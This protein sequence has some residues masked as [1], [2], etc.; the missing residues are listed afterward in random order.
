MP[1]LADQIAT[2]L[3]RA[4][5]KV[6]D[7]NPKAD[8]ICTS[9]QTLGARA[10]HQGRK[11]ASAKSD[12]NGIDGL[13]ETIKSIARS[14]ANL[15]RTSEQDKARLRQDNE[16]IQVTLADVR[17]RC[18]RVEAE[19]RHLRNANGNGN[20]EE[21]RRLNARLEE[22]R[23][24]NSRLNRENDDLRDQVRNSSASSRRI[25]KLEREVEIL[26]SSKRALE[27]EKVALVREKDELRARVEELNLEVG[28]MTRCSKCQRRQNHNCAIRQASIRFRD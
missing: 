28:K 1:T 2:R 20:A 18:E 21:V 27:G 13:D 22:L 6:H 26:Q 25:I 23:T 14:V 9:L 16:V 11:L 12:L 3:A 7:F 4:A 19:N 17:E 10:Q 24:L 15:S 8:L 5:Q